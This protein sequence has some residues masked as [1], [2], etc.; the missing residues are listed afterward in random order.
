MGVT[1]FV[2]TLA[3]RRGVVRGDRNWITVWLVLSGLSWLHQHGGKHEVKSVRFE[4]QPGERYLISHE[5]PEEGGARGASPPRASERQRAVRGSGS[6]A[7]P[8]RISEPPA[9]SG[10]EGA[11]GR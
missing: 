4:I 5:P 8:P 3:F 9:A 1:R 10:G 7:Q 2:K 11:A 6:G